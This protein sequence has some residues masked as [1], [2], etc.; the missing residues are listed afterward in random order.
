MSV[1]TGNL[2]KLRALEPQD[3]DT[4]YRWENDPEVWE[5]SH[6]QT[7]FSKHL[8]KTFIQVAAQDIYTNKQLRLM[9]DELQ[10]GKTIGATDLFDFEPMHDRVGLGILIDKNFREKGYASEA[11]R[12]MKNY[13]FDVLLM[14]QIYCNILE[15]NDK[16]I[17]LF[18]KEGFELI[19]N[20][21]EWIKTRNGY[22]NELIFQCIKK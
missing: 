5:V 4:L 12:L 6:T 9:I 14:H 16:S 2:V 19:G 11:I 21:K 22:K 1:L 3:V 7:P 15:D 10:T 13:V 17:N 18:M 20:K 8:L